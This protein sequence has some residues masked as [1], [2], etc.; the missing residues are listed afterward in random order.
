[1]CGRAKVE[2]FVSSGTRACG[3]DGESF[4][5]QYL[6]EGFDV[7]ASGAEGEGAGEGV[8]DCCLGLCRAA[9]ACGTVDGGI[10]G[11]GGS[12]GAG[13][14]ASAS[15]TTARRSRAC[16]GTT[17]W[18]LRRFRRYIPFHYFISGEAADREG[19]SFSNGVI[20]EIGADGG[21][22]SVAVLQ[23]LRSPEG[24]V[25]ESNG[26]C[27]LFGEEREVGCVDRD[28]VFGNEEIAVKVQTSG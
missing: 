5:I 26:G 4:G 17:R 1:L 22:T 7:R 20:G 18:R 15:S 14:R 8:G 13:V 9:V 16:R 28:F 25:V 6:L 21:G 12:E 24:D 3:G 27:G 11:H 23:N 10:L 19:E 2:G